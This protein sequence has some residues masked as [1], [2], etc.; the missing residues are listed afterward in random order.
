MGVK[1]KMNEKQLQ[2]KINATIWSACDTLRSSIPGGNYKDYALVMLFVKYLS[3]TYKEEKEKA[4]ELYDGNETMIDRYL[5]RSKFILKEECTF[6]YLYSKRNEDNIGEIINKALETITTLNGVKL[7][8]LFAGVDFNSEV[9]FGKKKEK[10]AILK[11]LLQDFNNPDIDLRPSKIGNLDVIGNAYEYLIARFAGDSGKKGGEFYTPAEVSQLLAKLVAPKENDRIYDPACGSGSLLLKASK[12]VKD[13]KV[14]VYGQESNSST[15]NLCR[16]NMFLHGVNDAHIEWGDTLANPLHLEHDDL[17]KFDVIV[18]NPPFSLDKWAKGFE[19]QNSS[20]IDGEG[21]KKDTFKMEATLDPYNRFGYGVPPKSIGDYAFIQHMLKSLA[22]GGRMAVVLPHG[23]LFR[24]A[25]EGIIRQRILEENLI[26]AVIGL[27]ENLFYG[28]SIPA[29]IVVFKK[30]RDRKDVVFIE[31]SREYE[32][33][34]NQNK[35]T[36]ENIQKILDTYLNYKEIE[37]YSHIATIQEIKENE[38]NLNIKR[39]VDTFEEEEEI[40]IE[41]TKKNIAEIEKELQVLEKELQES[42]KELG[43]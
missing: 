36:E 31:A 20:I 9:V 37:K 11:T 33:G 38:Y 34:K 43:L 15:Y 22:D 39:Y 27:P 16:M 19:P 40:D 18:S 6:D 21:K 29:T 4:K 7:L 10:N 30:N 24:G 13:K 28:V 8:N 23:T 3:D 32:K 5:S 1:N 2:D 26:D 42:L 14:S 25:S 17:M 35:L 12:E 41:E